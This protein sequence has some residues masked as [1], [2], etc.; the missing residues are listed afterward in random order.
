MLPMLQDYSVTYVPDRSVTD[1]SDT[2][3]STSEAERKMTTCARVPL[4]RAASGLATSASAAGIFVELNIQASRR[5]LKDGNCSTQP[6][7]KS[8]C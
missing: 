2:K 6:C 1:R 8:A 7:A 5:K 4:S 3:R